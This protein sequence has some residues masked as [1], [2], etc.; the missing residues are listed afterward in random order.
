MNLE[1]RNY[2]KTLYNSKAYQDKT[3]A[4]IITWPLEIIQQLQERDIV[5]IHPDTLSRLSFIQKQTFTEEQK[6]YMNVDQLDAIT[7]SN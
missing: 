1:E 7:V 4:H 6:S 5:R 2:A 3:Y